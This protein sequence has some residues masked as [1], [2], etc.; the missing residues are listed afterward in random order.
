MIIDYYSTYAVG[1]ASRLVGGRAR[2]TTG[3]GRAGG[4]GEE[5]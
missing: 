2:T 4:F 5:R 1:G 3:T